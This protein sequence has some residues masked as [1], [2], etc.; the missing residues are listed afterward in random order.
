MDSRSWWTH[1]DTEMGAE[2]NA[3]VRLK[4]PDE[5][6]ANLDAPKVRK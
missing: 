5:Q 4:G 6:L 2:I 1:R 3:L